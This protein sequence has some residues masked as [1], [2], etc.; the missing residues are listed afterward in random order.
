MFEL[1]AMVVAY[2]GSHGRKGQHRPYE[3]PTPV[4]EES[5]SEE[6]EQHVVVPG[7]SYNAL[8]KSLGRFSGGEATKRKLKSDRKP[9][10][11]DDELLDD[12]HS[13]DSNRG[14]ETFEFE[15]EVDAPDDHPEDSDDE[16]VSDPFEAHFEAPDEEA[17]SHMTKAVSGR[18]WKTEKGINRTEGR[19]TVLKPHINDDQHSVQRKIRSVKDL[20]LKK[21]LVDPATRAIPKFDS[22]Q[23]ALMPAISNYQ[24]LLYG[25]RTPTNADSLR[26]IACLHALNHVFKTRD[27][28]IKNNTRLSRDEGKTDLEFRDQGFTRPKVL[29]LLET[30][31]SCVRY[32]DTITE[33][34]EPDQQ[35]NKKRFQDAFV[36]LEEKYSEE[37]PLD[38]R[39]LFEANDDNE[40]KLGVKFTRKTLKYYS[41]FYNS[42][43]VLASPLGLRRAIKADE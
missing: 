16:D 38:F 43:I 29:I 11:E 6:E 35:E 13:E 7:Q 18:E 4:S 27:R 21:R 24:D 31:Q 30:R 23:T 3:P 10:V 17:L 42:D 9:E 20:K 37:R 8:L 40:F 19:M 14:K 32:M 33:L 28:I 25:G 34:C 12:V 26:N 1:C 36:Q 22:L 39:E 5:S 15:D 41:Q 2:A